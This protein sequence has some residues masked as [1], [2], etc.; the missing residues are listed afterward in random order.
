MHKELLSGKKILLGV[1]GSI[2]IYKSFVQGNPKQGIQAID[3]HYDII[4]R[5]SLTI[6]I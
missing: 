5:M 1:T 6:H 3:Q 4:D 2:A